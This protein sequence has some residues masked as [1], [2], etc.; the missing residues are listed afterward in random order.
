MKIPSEP[1]RKERI[2]QNLT[3]AFGEELGFS[4][5]YCKADPPLKKKIRGGTPL[6]YC[7]CNINQF[8]PPTTTQQANGWFATVFPLHATTTLFGCQP[9]FCE[10][11][12]HWVGLCVFARIEL[13]IAT[14]DLFQPSTL[15]CNEPCMQITNN[16]RHV[17]QG[18]EH[19]TWKW[20]HLS[21]CH[22]SHWLLACAS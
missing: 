5:Y 14:P 2:C 13:T 9:I 20:P 17:S 18:D 6:Y 3:E 10:T 21:E 7:R 1:I 4:I 12:F 16:D 19:C 15:P 22:S 11:V 8:C